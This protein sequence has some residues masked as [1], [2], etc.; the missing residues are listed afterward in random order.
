MKIVRWIL[1]R[2]LLLI[3][4]LTS[5]R[6]LSRDP[7]AQ[8]RIDAETRALQLFQFEGCPFCIKVRRE[9][10]RLNL[11]IALRD[12][13]ND[14]AAERELVDGGGQRQVPCLRIEGEGAPRWLYESSDIV[15]YL[16]RRFAPTEAGRDRL[17]GA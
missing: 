6:P 9:I 5:P 10:R 4:R 11:K 1:G 15:A 13:Q 14:R 8:A 3:D 17:A 2:L 7:S 16:R 12:A